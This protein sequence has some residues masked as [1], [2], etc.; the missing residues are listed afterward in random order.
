MARILVLK[1]PYWQT[2]ISRAR[3]PFGGQGRRSEEE[4]LEECF[5]SMEHCLLKSVRGLQY[6]SET[7][8]LVL[9]LPHDPSI[10]SMH[11]W[12]AQQVRAFLSGMSG[13]LADKAKFAQYAQA[14]EKHHID[15]ACLQSMQRGWLVAC[16]VPI[17]DQ[18]ALHRGLKIVARL[19]A[20]AIEYSHSV[21]L[22]VER[23]S[24]LPKM[25][26]SGKCDAYVQFK[27]DDPV[28]GTSQEF[29]ST[30]KPSSLNPQWSNQHFDL[31]VSD[32]SAPGQLVMRVM[33]HEVMAHDQLIGFHLFGEFFDSMPQLG[34]GWAVPHHRLSSILAKACAGPV[35]THIPLF[36]DR[37]LVMGDD[38]QPT[39][40]TLCFEVSNH[41]QKQIRLQVFGDQYPRS[42]MPS[43]TRLNLIAK[44]PPPPRATS[45]SSNSDDHA[46]RHQEAQ[47]A[48]TA[49]QRPAAGMHGTGDDGPILDLHGAA[50]HRHRHRHRQM[51]L[52]VHGAVDD[53]DG[54]VVPTFAYDQVS[55]YCAL[56]VNDDYTDNAAIRV[57]RQLSAQVCVCVCVCV[58]GS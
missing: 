52:P 50:G 54:L 31:H 55:Q 36:V 11:L 28:R 7:R 10:E 6:K 25:D 53:H 32:L 27:L 42:S 9:E 2:Q 51:D 43:T 48:Q 34:D 35:R 29:C 40:V 5:L 23:I 47:E 18:E 19:H 41:G 38:L 57:G 16:G 20:A 26:I 21:H 3:Q 17:G 4:V 1:Q 12:S 56:M 45:S 49:A 44:Q 30:Y 39:T 15:G 14:L 8:P 58:C 24:H 13:D 46:P 22:T 37:E 33:D